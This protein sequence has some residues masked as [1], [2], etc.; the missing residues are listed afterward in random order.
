VVIVRPLELR[1]FEA[2]IQNRSAQMQMDKRRED[3][4]RILAQDKPRLDELARE[5]ARLSTAVET[6][7]RE[8]AQQRSAWVAEME[9]TAGT[10]IRGAGPVF[11][12]RERAVSQAERQM[13][14]VKGRNLSRIAQNDREIAELLAHQQRMMARADSVHTDA[15]GFLARMEALRVLKGENR[16]VH[17]ASLFIILLVITLE[18]AP[19]MVKLLSTLSPY[20]PYDELLEQ[21]EF[22]IVAAA[23]Q[24]VLV[25]RHE[26]EADAE[27]M[28]SDY[29]RAIN[30]ELRLSAETSQLRLAAELNAGE[31]LIQRIANARVELAERLVEEW[32]RKE[33]AKIETDVGS[34]K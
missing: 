3:V 33:L 1:L 25:R 23:R 28:I 6:W 14:E 26:L 11:R 20:R 31:I 29:D 19:V 4:A 34:Y 13:N 12:E 21:R 2:E 8:V 7:R 17:W 27:W 24:Q 5:N 32:K 30:T 10:G 18:T 16:T 15:N 22:E 9:G